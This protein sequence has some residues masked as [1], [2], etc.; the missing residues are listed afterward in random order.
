MSLHPTRRVLAVSGA[1]ALGATALLTFVSPSADAA[2]VV[3]TFEFTGTVEEFVV[4]DGVCQV[5]VD[6]A[7]AEGGPGDGEL[8]GGLGGT[9]TGTPR[10]DAGRDARG[11]GRRPG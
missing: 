10:G 4:P 1:S 7:G 8:A 3:Q 6:A 5:T 2:P 9:A 11:A